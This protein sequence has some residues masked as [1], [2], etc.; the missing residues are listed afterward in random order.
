MTDVAVA[1]R[2][3]PTMPGIHSS[4][5]DRLRPTELKSHAHRRV[6][7]SMPAEYMLPGVGHRRGYVR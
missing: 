3:H 2:S 1:E 5:T 6:P 4:I 7:G